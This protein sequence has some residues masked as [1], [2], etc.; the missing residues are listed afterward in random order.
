MLLTKETI[1]AYTNRA[2]K[3]QKFK[4]GEIGDKLYITKMVA[5]SEQVNNLHVRAK[6]RDFEVD[7]DE[8]KELGGTDKGPCPLECLLATLA[9][10]LQQTALLYFTF[11]KVKLKS[12]KV[13]VE[14]IHDVRS[15]LNPK[16]IP[17][18]GFSDFKVTWFIDS[19]DDPKRIERV[20]DKVKD[21]CPVKGTVTRTQNF[22]EEITFP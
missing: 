21:I 15:S 8:P 6:I 1:E 13:K 14:A 20:L 9:N 12:V 10:C 3:M 18:P 2:R 11:F 22:T 19:D 4:V 16:E 7:N 17:L 5:F